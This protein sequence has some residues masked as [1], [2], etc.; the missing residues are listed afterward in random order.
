L[1]LLDLL[2]NRCVVARAFLDGVVEDRRVG[3]EARYRELFDV[4]C[5]RTRLERVAGDVVEPET[6]AAVVQGFRAFDRGTSSGRSSGKSW[7]KR[8]PIRS[9]VRSAGG[10]DLASRAY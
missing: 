1:A 2:P 5:E 4:A 10:Y 7:V 3:R 6:L 8:S 9:T